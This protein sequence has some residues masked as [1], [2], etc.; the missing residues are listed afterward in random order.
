MDSSPELHEHF[1]EC[2]FGAMVYL[3]IFLF[4][5]VSFFL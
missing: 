2:I 5:F 1:P 4:C 3:V